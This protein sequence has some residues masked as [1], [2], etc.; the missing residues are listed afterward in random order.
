MLSKDLTLFVIDE[1]YM[2]FGINLG[3][4]DQSLIIR[5]LQVVKRIFYMSEFLQCI[6][7]L[8]ANI[9]PISS[10]PK[11]SAFGL[12][13]FCIPKQRIIILFD[14]SEYLNNVQYANCNCLQMIAKSL[15]QNLL[16]VF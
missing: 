16:Q 5:P 3:L 6:I 10:R 11:A 8:L 14:L 1:C 9:H 13:Y 15:Y 2:L 4:D 12:A 7:S